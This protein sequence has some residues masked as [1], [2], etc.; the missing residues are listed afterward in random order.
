MK[1]IEVVIL[2]SLTKAH[3]FKA[4]LSSKSGLSRH[5][6]KFAPG[7]GYMDKPLGLPERQLC[8]SCNGSFPNP[9][10]MPMFYMHNPAMNM[11]M[12]QSFHP[13]YMGYRDPMGMPYQPSPGT[14]NINPYVMQGDPGIG[15]YG[16]LDKLGMYSG[17][18][19]N[20]PMGG[21]MMGGGMMG[22]PVMD[23]LSMEPQQEPSGGMSNDSNIAYQ[24]AGK[25]KSKK[26]SA[27]KTVDKLHP[28]YLNNDLNQ[29]ELDLNWML[30]GQNIPLQKWKPKVSNNL[31]QETPKTKATKEEP[32]LGINTSL[33]QVNLEEETEDEEGA[34]II[35]VL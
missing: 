4:S 27:R 32:N 26:K 11:M 13:S 20:P 25:S 8:A 12:M 14:A 24:N 30:Q 3:L 31:I 33:P 19:S 1:F 21:G 6:A 34:K 35:G 23:N 29:A 28:G 7:Y 18:M 15:N 2:L 17:M 22:T 9:Y 10:M 16:Q 5:S